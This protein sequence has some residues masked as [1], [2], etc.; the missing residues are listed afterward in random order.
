MNQSREKKRE[1]DVDA[2]FGLVD[3]DEKDH[4][5]GRDFALQAV[6]RWKRPDPRCRHIAR[7]E[8]AVGDSHHVAD[9][10]YEGNQ[11]NRDRKKRDRQRQA[12]GN[13]IICPTRRPEMQ[14]RDEAEHAEGDD[15]NGENRDENFQIT[16]NMLRLVSRVRAK[17]GR[18]GEEAGCHIASLDRDQSSGR[19]ENRDRNCEN[20]HVGVDIQRIWRNQTTLLRTGANRCLVTGL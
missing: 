12:F 5:R 17:Q 6:E 1:A 13:G 2:D 7:I 9:K 15:F 8:V 11:V 10:R 3:E 18:D 20:S 16:R 14:S 4:H 19:A